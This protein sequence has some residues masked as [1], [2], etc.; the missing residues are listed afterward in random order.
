MNMK[1]LRGWICLV[2]FILT[3]CF[4]GYNR[5]LMKAQNSALIG[6][7]VVA[8]GLT[9]LLNGGKQAGREAPPELEKEA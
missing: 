5:Y 7:A 6:M 4:I 3:C 8:V 1:S 9:L 2:V